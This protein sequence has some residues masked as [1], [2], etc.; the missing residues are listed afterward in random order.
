MYLG[1]GSTGVGATTVALLPHTGGYRSLFV[2]AATVLTFGVI[3]LTVSGIAAL[4][5]SRAKA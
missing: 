3:T 2:I 5:Q 1:I 4:K